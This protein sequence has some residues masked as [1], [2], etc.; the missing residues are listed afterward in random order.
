MSPEMK[1]II[2]VGMHKTGSS[3]IQRTF[4]QLKHPD[5][6]YIEWA[7]S[8][9]HSGLFVLLFEEAD[10]VGEYHSF[11]SR[12]PDFQKTLPKLHRNWKHQVSK[13]L[14]KAGNKTV[15]FSAEGI[16]GPRFDSSVERLHD[17]FAS[18]SRDI[19]IIGYARPPAGFMASAFQQRLKG[20]HNT[21]LSQSVV[22][23]TYRMRFE[24]IDTTF[25]KD[26]VTIKEFSAGRL[27]QGD[28]VQDFAQEISV[29]AL[30]EDRII[31]TNE[32]LSLEA[33][34]LLYVQ[35][36]LG[37][38]FVSGY[39]LAHAANNAFI[40]S[41]GKIG[42]RKFAFSSKMLVPILEKE[43][44]DI[45]WMEERLGHAF[46][47]PGTDHKDAIDS[48][49]DLVDIALGQFD[50]VQE[51]LGEKAV[52]GPATTDNLVRAL[53]VLR[54]DCYAAV[55]TPRTVGADHSLGEENLTLRRTFAHLLW[56]N[57]GKADG[58]DDP[59]ELSAEWDAV[60]TDYIE[61]A[62]DLLRRLERNGF[63]LAET[64]EIGQAD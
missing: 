46:S 7:R 17:F 29:A 30:P 31:R 37:Q 32:S 58:L 43:R 23:P 35:R 24:K 64:K 15:I 28:V 5:L 62:A 22:P 51:V 63:K 48:L 10:K 26:R 50:A 9:N 16:S 42:T 8:G 19:L 27:V 45:A 4:A 61:K 21:N 40:S 60:R 34:A 1:V 53:E 49:D 56:V 20:G 18:W 47:D 38:G 57:E 11:K 59:A 33:V 6:E 39:N 14:S 3:S 13:Q 12:G 54:E 55:G 41:L 25:G 2:H 36:Q 44:D 52:N